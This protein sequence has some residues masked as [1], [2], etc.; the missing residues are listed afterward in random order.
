MPS[1]VVWPIKR[2]HHT[3]FVQVRRSGVEPSGGCLLGF[4]LWLATRLRW[5]LSH[6]RSWTVE[7]VAP[8]AL[9]QLLRSQRR[10]LLESYQTEEAAMKVAEKIAQRAAEGDFD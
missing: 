9:R 3:C 2:P 1:G 7:V 4:P 8:L 5:Q 10:L 6:N